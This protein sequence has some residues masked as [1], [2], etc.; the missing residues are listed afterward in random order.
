MRQPVRGRLVVAAAALLAAAAELAVLR[1]AAAERGIA[2]IH[3]IYSDERPDEKLTPVSIGPTDYISTNDLARILGATKFWR[4]E[5]RKLT[6]RIGEHTLRLTVDAPLV[7]VDEQAKNLVDAPRLLRGTVYVP[8]SILAR[9]GPWGLLANTLWDEPTHTIRFRGTVHTV[10]QV[11][12][13]TR[14]HVTEVGATLLGPV[15]PRLLYATPGELRILFGGG[16]LDTARS[17]A[18]GL[19]TGG[20]VEEVPEGVDLRLQ[21]DAKARGYSLSAGSGRL[22][23]AITDDD[24]LIDAGLF[25]R[26]EPI[27]LGDPDHRLRTIVI[28]PGHG[29]KDPG[30][31]LPDGGDE[32]DLALDV[33]RAL[34]AALAQ[35]TDARVILTRDGDADVSLERRAEIANEAGAQLFVSVHADAGGALRAGGFRIYALSPESGPSSSASLPVPLGGGNSGAA[36]AA[37]ELRPWGAAQASE[38]G[39]GMALGQALADALARAFPGASVSF[40]PASV[41]VLESVLCPAVLIEIAP[42]PRTTPEA[43]SLKGYTIAEVAQ[44]VA[45]AVR[46]F[47]SGGRR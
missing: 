46:D 43:Q 41:N 26:L 47:A 15:P 45:Q 11:Q 14:D 32:K 9:F 4:P 36:V 12:L 17:L 6:L 7:L 24:G 20:S 37:V 31:P 33:A 5:L 42:P 25:T 27:S 38:S 39:P 19:V 34:R 35:K 8:A 22:K 23:I 30:A 40:R 18:G 10:R 16:T 28:D 13:W 2:A 3:V 1:P 29:G 21:L 44:T